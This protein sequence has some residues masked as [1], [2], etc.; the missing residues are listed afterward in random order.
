MMAHPQ[1]IQRGARAHM[2][3]HAAEAGVARLYAGRGLTIAAERWRGGGAEIDLIARDG[4]TVVFIEVKSS[5][6]HAEAAERLGPWQVR[7]IVQAAQIFC[8][9][10]PKGQFTDVRFDL[11]LVDAQGRIDVIENALAA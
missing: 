2:A 11:A 9:G 8:D 3:G 6:T 4:D 7:R 5:R 1:R 10:E